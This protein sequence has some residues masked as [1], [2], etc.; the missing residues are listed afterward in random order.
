MIVEALARIERWANMRLAQRHFSLRAAIP[1]ARKRFK[2]VEVVIPHIFSV[3]PNAAGTGLDVYMKLGT[4][5]VKLDEEND[6]EGKA[7][8]EVVEAFNRRRAEAAKAR[9]RA[10]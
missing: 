6:P 8:A 1:R 7:R 4:T 9:P 2:P 10:S 3:T 5:L